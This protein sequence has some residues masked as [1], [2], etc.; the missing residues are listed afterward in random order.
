MTFRVGYD[1]GGVI[2]DDLKNGG[3][4]VPGAFDTIAKLV[5]K[6]GADNNFIISKAAKEPTATRSWLLTN[7]FYGRTGFDPEN[8]LF[9]HE[10]HEKAGLAH[11]LGLD[12]FMSDRADVL[13]PMIDT[14]LK[15]LFEIKGPQ[16][17][18]VPTSGM[19]RIASWDAFWELCGKR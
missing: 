5:N 9:C 14:R 8:L 2:I 1:I 19:R 17:W 4:E 3:T 7:N 15:C 6:F 13:R 18:L 16:T 12:C 10:R 11:K